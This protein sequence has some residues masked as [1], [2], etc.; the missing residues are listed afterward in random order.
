VSKGLK[1]RY[2]P[3]IVGVY[4]KLGR[5]PGAGHSLS[6]LPQCSDLTGDGWNQMDEQTWRTGRMGRA[7]DWGARAREI[8]SV[9]AVRSFEQRGASRWLVT[10]V[11]PLVSA[12]DAALALADIPNRFLVN[13]RRKVTVVKEGAV[14]GI[15]GPGDSSIWA[16]EQE[17]TGSMG[18]GIARYLSGTAG[19]VLYLVVASGLT[20]T[21][22]WDGIV[23]V[24]EGIVSRIFDLQSA[25][26]E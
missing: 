10:E 18:S 6:M 17:T 14:S 21:W 2:V 5:K 1:G 12:D 13:P 25:G 19:S 24:A 22:P 15:A 7:S 16:Y 4:A 23:S 11:I 20:D 9:T 8:Q 26:D 3:N